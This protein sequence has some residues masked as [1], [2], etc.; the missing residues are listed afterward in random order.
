MAFE[1]RMKQLVGNISA[2]IIECSCKNCQASNA[3]DLTGR[4]IIIEGGIFENTNT[5]TEWFMNFFQQSPS[6]NGMARKDQVEI[7]KAGYATASA[8]DW[9]SFGREEQAAEED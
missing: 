1:K 9:S 2:T 7:A 5:L 8:H 3:C 4:S 6:I